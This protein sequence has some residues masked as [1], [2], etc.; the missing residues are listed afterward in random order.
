M[1]KG[2]APIFIFFAFAISALLAAAALKTLKH[3]QVSLAPT[4]FPTASTPPIPSPT[5]TPTASFWPTSSPELSATPKTQSSSS[6]HVRTET[7]GV[8]HDVTVTG[9]DSYGYKDANTSISI[10]NK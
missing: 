7:N 2:F 6:T 10:N 1:N 8:V 3:T 4:T 5:P 9:K